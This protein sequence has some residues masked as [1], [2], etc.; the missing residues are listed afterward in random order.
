MPTFATPEPISAAIDVIVGSVRISASERADTVVDVQPANPSR[1]QDVR[2]AEDTRVEY[3]GGTLTVRAPR[4]RNLGLFGKVGSVIVTIALPDG[5]AVRAD[6]SVSDIRAEGRLGDCRVK[7][8]AGDIQLDATASV[9]L[10]TDAGA[11]AVD[12]I[13][14]DADITTGS[15]Q[16]RLGAVE[17]N[18]A[19]RN[20][21]GDNWIGTVTGELRVKA[22]NGNVSVE[23]SRSDVTANTA[24]GSVRIG[25]V[26]RGTASLSTAL[27]QIEIGIHQG[28]AARLDVSTQFG[29][30]RNE[31]DTTD[32]PA[33]TDETVDVHART[34]Y[35]DVVIRR[36]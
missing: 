9:E 34:S 11:I 15:G 35:G 5:S 23:H 18:A 24:N 29:R 12:R 33:A 20:S 25:D 1:E 2:A 27:G 21:N 14:G 6:T 28:T 22:A 8:S 10:R 31:L 36:A 16:I 4:G 13:A 19:L 26:T 17:G 7:T 32:R 30:V 3:T